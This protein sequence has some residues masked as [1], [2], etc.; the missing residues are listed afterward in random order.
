VPYL[1]KKELKVPLI[2]LPK[3]ASSAPRRKSPKHQKSY[4]E[5]IESEDLSKTLNKDLA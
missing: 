4:T 2:N 3:T 1:Q 5:D